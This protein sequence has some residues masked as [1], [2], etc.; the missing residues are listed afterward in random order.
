MALM[1]S[2]V[3]RVSIQL[4]NRSP[5]SGV[6]YSGLTIR[7]DRGMPAY[8]RLCA[9]GHPLPLLG[10][11]DEGAVYA[12]PVRPDVALKLLHAPDDDRL[13]KELDV[14]S[15]LGAHD[16]GPRLFG[17]SILNDR[18]LI[19]SERIFGH[20]IE[21][22]LRYG[23]LT[24]HEVALFADV[25]YRIVHAGLCVGE[26]NINPNVM[27]GHRY[28]ERTPRAFVVDASQSAAPMTANE[29]AWRVFRF[30]LLASDSPLVRAGIAAA[31]PLIH[32]T[33][34]RLRKVTTR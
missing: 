19:A 8:G 12:H 4:A 29:V 31:F 26:I 9:Q 13:S 1:L 17:A 18:A 34:L 25:S 3:H 30:R 33:W 21:D 20:T 22:M 6:D 32:A 16:I 27:V 28:H 2:E 11:G 23:F 15:A 14:K 7:H 5:G 24:P 10:E